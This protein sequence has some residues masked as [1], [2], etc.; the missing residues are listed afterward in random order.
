MPLKLVMPLEDLL[1][2]GGGHHLQ[3]PIGERPLIGPHTAHYAVSERYLL[4]IG[5]CAPDCAAGTYDGL[6]QGPS[7]G[8]QPPLE[9][10]DV[11]ISVLLRNLVMDWSRG[12]W[13]DS[14]Y[15]FLLGAVHLW[16]G[17][18]TIWPLDAA[19]GVR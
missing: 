11:F 8:Q 10:A 19:K 9:H 16:P 17:T 5:P 14:R 1:P 13:E 12:I 15:N 6:L 4:K 18:F 2:P 7:S 3:K